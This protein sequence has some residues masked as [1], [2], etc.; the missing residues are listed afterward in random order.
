MRRVGGRRPGP[1]RLKTL[2]VIVGLVFVLT[3]V[4]A[5]IGDPAAAS[6][7]GRAGVF[8]RALNALRDVF[9]DPGAGLA[10]IAAGILIGGLLFWLAD[11]R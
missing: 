10:M 4:F 3:G 11:R 8:S 7:R 1:A 2:A 5:I 6:G 9:G